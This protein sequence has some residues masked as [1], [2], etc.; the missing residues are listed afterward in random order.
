MLYRL[1]NLYEIKNILNF[2]IPNHFLTKKFQE[3]IDG[4]VF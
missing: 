4:Y 3:S 1:Q 2:D